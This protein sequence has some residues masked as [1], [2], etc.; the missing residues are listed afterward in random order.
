MSRKF[1]SVAEKQAADRERERARAEAANKRRA[2]EEWEAAQEGAVMM[3]EA[4]REY[5]QAILDAYFAGLASPATGAVSLTSADAVGCLKVLGESGFAEHYC[6]AAVT[7]VGPNH[8]D[9]LDW[10]CSHV[11]EHELPP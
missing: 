11:P 6:Q 9:A 7:A 4:N 5:V 1:A 2:K 8:D 3:S 10:L